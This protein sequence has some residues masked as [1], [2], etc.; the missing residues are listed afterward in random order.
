[1]RQKGFPKLRDCGGFEILKCLPNSRDL[2]DIDSSLAARFL[3]PKLGVSQGKIYVCPIQKVLPINAKTQQRD[4]QGMEKCI[5]CA[6]EVPAKDLR[7]HLS[8]CSPEISC[9]PDIC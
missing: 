9:S 1:M 3:K 7:A 2:V 4:S 8:S 6:T 5:M